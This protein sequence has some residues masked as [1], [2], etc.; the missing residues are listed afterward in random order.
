MWARGY[1]CST[2]GAVDES[3][4]KQYVENQGE[5]VDTANVKI[6]SLEEPF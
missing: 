2:V 6:V 5:D 3:T 4:I 1:F